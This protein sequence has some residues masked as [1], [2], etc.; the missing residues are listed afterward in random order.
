YQPVHAASF[1]LRGGRC[2]TAVLLPRERSA[3]DPALGPG[4]CRARRTV[5]VMTPSIRIALI[6]HDK[7]KSD[8]LDWAR[9]NRDLLAH[10]DLSATG[11]TGSLL[12]RGIDL[13][14]PRVF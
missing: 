11:T 3:N 8:L 2:R 1:C 5:A 13:H 6:A 12:A 10:H 9:A 14:V 4:L 7:R